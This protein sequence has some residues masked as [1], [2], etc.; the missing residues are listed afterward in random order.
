MLNH[1]SILSSARGA[2]L[3]LLC[4][5]A[6]SGNGREARLL[7]IISLEQGHSH[8]SDITYRAVKSGLRRFALRAADGHT[9]NFDLRAEELGFLELGF[10]VVVQSSEERL[11]QHTVTI[12]KQADI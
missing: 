4:L 3:T 7:T 6:C 9:H 12:Q 5:L 8:G 2:I 1:S 11:H 10:P